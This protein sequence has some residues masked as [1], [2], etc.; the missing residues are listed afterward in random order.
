ME[1]IGIDIGTTSI[2][3]VVIDTENGEV[4]NSI[5]QN[6]NAFLKTENDFEK[7]SRLKK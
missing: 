3:G 7:Y 5:S 6:S 4:L 1:A 2:C